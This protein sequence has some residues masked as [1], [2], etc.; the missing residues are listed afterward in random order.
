MKERP[1]VNASDF[2]ESRIDNETAT[3]SDGRSLKEILQGLVNHASE[4]IR[5]EVQLARAE[6]REDVTHYARASS[7]VGSGGALALYAVFFLL[8]S[9]VYALQSAVAPWLAALI[10]AVAVGIVAGILYLVGRKKLAQAS[11]KPDKTIRRLE[12]NV[13]WFKNQTK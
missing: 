1:D 6:V 10:V 12:D 3:R 7:L 5:S 13:R 2:N 11:L 9:G 8:L 4:I